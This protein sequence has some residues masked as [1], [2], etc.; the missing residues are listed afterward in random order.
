M[1]FLRDV[2]LFRFQIDPDTITGHA[3]N[4]IFKK[5]HLI[6]ITLKRHEKGDENIIRSCGTCA[7]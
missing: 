1:L 2:A 4:V 6:V 3:H 7:Y 5:K